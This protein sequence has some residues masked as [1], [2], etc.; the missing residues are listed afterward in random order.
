MY[1]NSLF[2][3]RLKCAQCP[4]FGNI[5]L[6]ES[7]TIVLAQSPNARLNANIQSCGGFIRAQGPNR[8]MSIC[9]SP[10][11]HCLAALPGNH[12]PKFHYATITGSCSALR[13]Q[14]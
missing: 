8:Q 6:S 3:V 4:S 1:V 5:P 10:W 7:N 13:E 12:Q 2:A 11:K 9:H 14:H